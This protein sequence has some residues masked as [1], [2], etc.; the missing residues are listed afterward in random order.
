VAATFGVT[1]GLG[2]EVGFAV[3]V[4]VAGTRVTVAACVG[5]L[6]LVFV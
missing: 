3:F 5:V 4:G 6:G 2:V 1:V